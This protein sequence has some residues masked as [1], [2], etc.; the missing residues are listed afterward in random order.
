ME[1]SIENQEEVLTKGER[2]SQRILDVA[3]QLF[4]EKGF[5]GSSLREIAEGVGIREPGLYRHF[6][7]K[8]AIYEAV[9]ERGLMPMMNLLQALSEREDARQHLH[10]LPLEMIELLE[11]HPSMAAL[12]QRALLSP[13]QSVAE[14]RMAGWLET[15]FDKA[16]QVVSQ[17]SQKKAAG[18]AAGSDLPDEMMLN[19]MMINMFNLCVG[20]FTCASFF[21]RVGVQ[22]QGRLLLAQ[23]ALLSWLSS[24]LLKKMP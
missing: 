15:L 9:L 16:R 20:Y 14:Q 11:Q 17:L 4:A 1:E 13:S 22:D 6:A 2:T 12:F 21:D 10:R 8:E 23:K 7:N 3:E 19:L 18:G 24:D 5:E